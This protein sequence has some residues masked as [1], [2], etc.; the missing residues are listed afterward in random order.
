MNTI[1]MGW[2]SREQEAY[3]VARASIL[4]RTSIPLKIIPLKLDHLR[5]ILRRPIEHRD[6][7]LW[8]PISRAPMSTEFAVSRFCVPFLQE[9][10][11]ALFCDCDILCWEDIQNL[12]DLADDRFAVMVCKHR[13]ASWAPS[14]PHTEEMREMWRRA[15]AEPVL[16]QQLLQRLEKKLEPWATDSSTSQEK[17]H[18]QELCELLSKTGQDREE[19]VRKVWGE[20]LP[21][22]PSR[23]R[24]A[25]ADCLALPSLSLGAPSLKMD[26]QVQ[27]YYARKNWSSVILY[28]CSHPDHATLTLQRLNGWPGRDLH[29]FKWLSDEVIGELPVKWNWLI[30]VTKGMPN[31]EGIW[32]FTLGGPWI[33]GWHG[34][35]YDATW[36]CEKAL[37]T[38]EAVC[39]Q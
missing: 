9:Q 11:W 29:A 36:R 32:H 5:G 25:L 19:A 8:C 14:T 30:N 13:H 12:F 3:E 38:E 15:E 21:N 20:E 37:L 27:T 26:G 4:R 35:L 2:D 18:L 31:P 6:G 23:L 34:A 10:G 28:N 33:R 39:A 22:A 7:Q 24:Q 16:L 17:K 1:Y